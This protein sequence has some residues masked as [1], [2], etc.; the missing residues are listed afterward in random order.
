M[1]HVKQ[2]Q[3]K[4]C[5]FFAAFYRFVPFIARSEVAKLFR[6]Q[7]QQMDRPITLP[8]MHARGV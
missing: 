7:Q 8:L 4:T 6:R 3:D 5:Q 1:D 2:V